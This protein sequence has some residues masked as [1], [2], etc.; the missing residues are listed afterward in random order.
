[1]SKP[2]YYPVKEMNEKEIKDAISFNIGFEKK[3]GFPFSKSFQKE[4][5]KELRKRS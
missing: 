3:W 4:L 1:M 2:K 5:K